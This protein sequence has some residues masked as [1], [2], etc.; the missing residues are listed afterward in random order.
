MNYKDRHGERRVRL[1]LLGVVFALIP[2]LAPAEPLAGTIGAAVQ[3][4]SGWIDFPQPVDFVKG[5]RLRLVIGGTATK[6]LVRMLA[7]GQSRDGSE[8]L[9]GGPIDVPKTRVIELVL[10]ENRA[11]VIQISVHGGAN[12]WGK[13]PLPG[14]GPAALQS[15]ERLALVRR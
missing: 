6:I 7:K 10:G 11:Q 12:P 15:V 5:E 4:G 14:N 3:Y 13:F 1:Y 2:Q 8:G 9:V